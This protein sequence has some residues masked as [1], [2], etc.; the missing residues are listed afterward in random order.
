MRSSALGPRSPS[1]VGTLNAR[2][3]DG[4]D[5]P[6]R[7]RNPVTL[8]RNSVSGLH[9]ARYHRKGKG[10]QRATWILFKKYVNEQASEKEK[11]KGERE[12]IRRE[13]AGNCRTFPC[14]TFE[15]RRASFDGGGNREKRRWSQV[16]SPHVFYFFIEYNSSLSLFYLLFPYYFP[17]W[18]QLLVN[19]AGERPAC[20]RLSRVIRRNSCLT[21][22]YIL[23]TFS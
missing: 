11:N 4:P 21:F 1:Q 16:G 2:A 14:P 18:D 22:F 9:L 23:L 17:S 3:G 6:G 7:T 19:V 8:P 12:R 13:I 15:I 10:T 20:R 5:P